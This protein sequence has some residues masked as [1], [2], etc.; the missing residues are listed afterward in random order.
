MDEL[1]YR[2]YAPEREPSNFNTHRGN[3]D[4]IK[5]CEECNVNRFYPHFIV[6]SVVPKILHLGLI[7]T[8]SLTVW[9]KKYTNK[10]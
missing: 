2:Y 6:I 4:Q 9:I 5:W 10:Q 7:L 3:M 8:C 1:N